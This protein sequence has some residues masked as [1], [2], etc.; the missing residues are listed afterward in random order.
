MTLASC[1]TIPH[2]RYPLPSPKYAVTT[3]IYWALTILG[4]SGSERSV[5]NAPE[6][7]QPPLQTSALT[8]F[9]QPC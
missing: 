3:A 1:I 8:S 6:L 7:K 9:T 5:H 2:R 4:K